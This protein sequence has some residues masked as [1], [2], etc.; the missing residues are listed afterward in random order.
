MKKT[1]IQP[2]TEVIKLKTSTSI[3]E[4]VNISGGTRPEVVDTKK[5]TFTDEEDDDAWDESGYPS[6]NVWDN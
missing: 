5:Q 2:H 6:Y 1:Y 4:N 3:L